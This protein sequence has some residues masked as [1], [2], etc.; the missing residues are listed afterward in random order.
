M[1][2]QG[3]T[4]N[5]LLIGIICDEIVFLFL[6]LFF[7]TTFFFLVLQRIGLSLIPRVRRLL[8]ILLV[9]NKTISIISINRRQTTTHHQIILDVMTTSNSL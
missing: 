5:Q 3:Y 7:S 2:K 9:L 6:F 1:L 8:Y 4:T